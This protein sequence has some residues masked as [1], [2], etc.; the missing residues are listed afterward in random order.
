MLSSA[1]AC[2]LFNF[3]PPP[4][5]NYIGQMQMYTG[6]VRSERYNYRGPAILHL[7][8]VPLLPT[9]QVSAASLPGP[10]QKLWKHIEPLLLREFPHSFMI[11]LTSSWWISRRGIC[12]RMG[13]LS[14]QDSSK[15]FAKEWN[16]KSRS[17]D[18]H[19]DGVLLLSYFGVLII[20]VTSWSEWS[21][22]TKGEGCGLTMHGR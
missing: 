20:Y 2:L 15:P 9:M 17:G 16:W 14:Y 19:G 8:D 1:F 13:Y 10:L 3:C 7:K 4:Q 18:R 11:F 22:V 6:D 12:W 21:L 5:V